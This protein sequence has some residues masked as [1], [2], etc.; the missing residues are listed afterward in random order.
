MKT[1]K[2]QKR[3]VLFSKASREVWVEGLTVCEGVDGKDEGE[4]D[5]E[6]DGSLFRRRSQVGHPGLQEGKSERQ[7]G[8]VGSPKDKIKRKDVRQE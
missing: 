7:S 1:E 4:A 2:G 5:A 3:Q 8:S 6:D